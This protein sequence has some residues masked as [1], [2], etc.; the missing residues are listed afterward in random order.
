MPEETIIDGE[1]LQAYRQTSYGVEGREPFALRIGQASEALRGL[2]REHGCDC[3]AYVT[4]FNPYSEPASAQHNA[5]NQARLRAE[6]TA[7]GLPFL[8]G[9]GV[10]ADPQWR[11]EPSFLVFGLKLQ[12]TRALGTSYL[13]NAIV[14][15]G[16]DAVPQLVLLR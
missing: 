13:Q 8:P 1:L 4:A 9:V 10:G 2:Y 3:A 16:E 11:G 14:W 5:E 7:S 15:C 12:Q 6:V